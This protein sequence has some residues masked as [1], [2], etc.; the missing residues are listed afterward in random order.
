MQAFAGRPLP[1]QR[2]E[3]V[4]EELESPVAELNR[5]EA[6]QIHGGSKTL[7]RSIKKKA[8]DTANALVSLIAG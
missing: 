8:D 1:S 2:G 6:E 5:R 3:V 7:A 4:L